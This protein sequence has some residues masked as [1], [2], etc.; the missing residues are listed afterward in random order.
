VDGS[1]EVRLF[2]LCT[3]IMLDFDAF[4]FFVYSYSHS[5]FANYGGALF[6][7]PSRPGT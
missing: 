2:S 4:F 5:A 7:L 6:N 1:A 3:R